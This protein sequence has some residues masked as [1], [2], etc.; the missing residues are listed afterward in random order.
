MVMNAINRGGTSVPLVRGM[1]LLN[2]R[3]KHRTRFQDES[4]T[5]VVSCSFGEGLATHPF[6]RLGL[7]ECRLMSGVK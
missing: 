4:F 5:C 6:V 1:H 3:Y 7:R 2:N